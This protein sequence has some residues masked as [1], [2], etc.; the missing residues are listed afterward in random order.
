M[1]DLRRVHRRSP[2]ATNWNQALHLGLVLSLVATLAGTAKTEDLLTDHPRP[3]YEDLEDSDAMAEDL[4]KSLANKDTYSFSRGWWAWDRLRCRY[5]D[6]GRKSEN[7]LKVLAAIFNGLMLDWHTELEAKGDG[8]LLYIFF[9][10]VSGDKRERA[11]DV[12]GR[13][14]RRDVRWGWLPWPLGR[15][16]ADT[17]LLR[18]YSPRRAYRGREDAFQTDRASEFGKAIHRLHRESAVCEQ[19]FIRQG[20]RREFEVGVFMSLNLVAMVA[21]DWVEKSGNDPFR[22]GYM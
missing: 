4:P 5:V 13:I 10:T 11:L 6:G 22:C 7:Q 18:A 1:T 9:T 20:R 15:C 8:D 2:V 16:C 3:S 17:P 12:D 14:L 19:S 21:G